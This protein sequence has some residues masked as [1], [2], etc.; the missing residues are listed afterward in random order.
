METIHELHAHLETKGNNISIQ[1][2]ESLLRQIE[3]IFPGLKSCFDLL[4]DSTINISKETPGGADHRQGLPGS[5]ASE[6]KDLN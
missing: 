5:T 3:I 1:E 6:W 2:T 4:T